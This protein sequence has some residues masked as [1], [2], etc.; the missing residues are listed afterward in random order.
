MAFIPYNKG[1]AIV[2]TPPFQSQNLAKW[3]SSLQW[4]IPPE[5]IVIPVVLKVKTNLGFGSTL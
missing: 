2:I 1:I 3:P 4:G 5:G